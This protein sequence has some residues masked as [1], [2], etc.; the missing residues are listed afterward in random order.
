MSP[1]DEDV[2]RRWV[3]E[4]INQGNLDVADEVRAPLLAD[5]A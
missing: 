5:E 1:T 2:V 4:M 3:E